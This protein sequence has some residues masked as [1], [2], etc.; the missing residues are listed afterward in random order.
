MRR[1]NVDFLLA[2][3]VLTSIA[4]RLNAQ[5]KETSEHHDGIENR[6]WHIARYQGN[7]PRRADE[8][9]LIETKVAAEIT[10]KNGRIEGSAG[11]GALVGDYTVSGDHL[12]IH[13]DFV[14]AGLCLEGEV[15]NGLVISALRASVRIEQN[16]DRVILRDRDGKAQIL[17]IPYRRRVKE[18]GASPF[19][20]S[21]GS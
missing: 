14:L 21:P 20:R 6:W 8:E 4:V 2:F 3:L 11:C 13:A 7:N 9:G 15:Q 10:F 5:S 18:R 16:D 12:T 17:L 1:I 19:T